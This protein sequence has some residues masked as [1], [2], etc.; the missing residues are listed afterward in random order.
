[1]FIGIF[2]RNN[3]I[4][5]LIGV[6]GAVLFSLYLIHDLQRMMN[7]KAVQ[8]SPDEFVFASVSIYLDVINIFLMILQIVGAVQNS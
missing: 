5:L 7:G 1:M 3:W 6:A 4:M 2:W 8:I